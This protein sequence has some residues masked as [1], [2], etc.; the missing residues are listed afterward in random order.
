MNLKWIFSFAKQLAKNN[1]LVFYLERKIV[2]PVHVI[3]DQDEMIVDIRL[4]KWTTY[5]KTMYCLKLELNL[6]IKVGSKASIFTIYSVMQ[7]TRIKSITESDCQL[8]S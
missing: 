1:F 4:C 8:I 6:Q 2:G 5:L 7:M 3:R